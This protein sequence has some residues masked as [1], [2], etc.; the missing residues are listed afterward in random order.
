VAV[1]LAE[2]QFL[3]KPVTLAL[4]ARPVDRLRVEKCFI[5]PVELLLD[6]FDAALSVS[7]RN[8]EGQSCAEARSMPE[9][10]RKI[11]LTA[12]STAPESTA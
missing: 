4:I 12:P 10:A 6:G 5:E 1:D 11:T 3:P 7:G 2:R 8:C 9:A